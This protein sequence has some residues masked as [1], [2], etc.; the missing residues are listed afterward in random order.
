MEQSKRGQ[1]ISAY[2]SGDKYEKL[3]AICK[4][5]DLPVNR[6]VNNAIED[7]IKKSDMEAK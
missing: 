3:M 4:R 7:Y 6:I 5:L 1:A 2:L